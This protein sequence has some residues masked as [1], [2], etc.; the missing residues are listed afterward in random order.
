MKNVSRVTKFRRLLL[1][2]LAINLAWGFAN[3]MEAYN[4]MLIIANA[5]MVI[6][7]AVHELKKRKQ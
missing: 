3:D 4:T 6:V 1:M 5:S 7:A 2:L